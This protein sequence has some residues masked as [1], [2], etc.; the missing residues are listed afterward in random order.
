M[1]QMLAAHTTNQL[2]RERAWAPF[3]W[4]MENMPMGRDEMLGMLLGMLAA[5][6]RQ[7][8]LL[9]SDLVPV[10]EAFAVAAF[11]AGLAER[12][13]RLSELLGHDTVLYGHGYGAVELRSLMIRREWPS[14]IDRKALSVQLHRILDIAEGG[15]YH[16]LS[17]PVHPRHS[18][19]AE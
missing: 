2:L 17:H 10:R 1:Q 5:K 11:H 14:F 3:V 15:L 9:G 18:S 8:A 4:G 7:E 16:A 13:D 12:V 19:Q 6:G